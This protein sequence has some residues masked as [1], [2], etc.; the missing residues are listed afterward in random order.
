[1]ADLVL[2]AFAS[3]A[4]QEF[5]MSSQAPWTPAGRRIEWMADPQP[6]R[7][8]TLL[9]VV[10]VVDDQESYTDMMSRVLI[11]YGLQVFIAN[12]ANQAFGLLDSVTPDLI[13]LDV[14]MPGVD[15]IAFLRR[16]RADPRL[17][18]VPVLLVT[19]YLDTLERGIAAGAQGYLAKPFSAQQ[20]RAAIAGFLEVRPAD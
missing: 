11:E 12:D 17:G 13:L 10:M 8:L 18:I 7:D 1:L 19:A 15:G 2:P 5:V 9:P 6:H 20:L 16:L 14:M 3:G 4:D